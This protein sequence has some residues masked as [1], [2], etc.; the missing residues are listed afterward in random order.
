MILQMRFFPASTTLSD[1]PCPAA[2]LIPSS[3]SYLAS[4][5]RRLKLSAHIRPMIGDWP[6]QLYSDM[7]S[8]WGT[9]HEPDTDR[10]RNLCRYHLPWCYIGKQR[11]DAAF[12]ARTSDAT[13]YLALFFAEPSMPENGMDRQAIFL[14]LGMQPVRYM[15]GSLPPAL[16]VASA[17]ILTLSNTPDSRRAHRFIRLP[18]PQVS[19]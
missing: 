18:P 1:T 2:G 13:L 4:L 10:R 9:V 6:A 14:G 7:L 5:A 19:I 8:S 15:A 3:P 12:A 16:I 11:L 17:S